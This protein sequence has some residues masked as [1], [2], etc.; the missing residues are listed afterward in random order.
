[1]EGQLERDQGASQESDDAPEQGGD[2]ELADDPF[3]VRVIDRGS[4]DGRGVGHQCSPFGAVAKV[5]KRK[6]IRIEK[7]NSSSP[8][9][10]KAASWVRALMARPIRPMTVSSPPPT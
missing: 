3:V 6:M 7:T 9:S 10:E 2:G 8:N 4:S 1:R 5:M